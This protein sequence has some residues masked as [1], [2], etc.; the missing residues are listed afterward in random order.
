MV[1]PL[2]LAAG[3]SCFSTEAVTLH[4]LTNAWV[5]NQFLP[6][7]VRIEGTEGEPGTCR[8]G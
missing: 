1:L 7:R 6:D 4:L 8:I 3:A 5:V 2:A